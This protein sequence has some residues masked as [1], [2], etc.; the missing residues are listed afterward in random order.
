MK[1]MDVLKLENQ[2]C[3]P[4]YA[5]SRQITALYRPLLEALGLTYPQYLVLMVLWEHQEITVKQLGELLLL[6]SGT[7]TP[8]LKR[9]EEKGWVERTRSREDERVVNISLTTAGKKLKQKAAPIPEQLVCGIEMKEKDLK[10]LRD[11]L[12][13]MLAGIT[14]V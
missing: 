14:Q 1:S 3:F 5:A 9:M 10:T 7:L 12:N 6:D 4:L 11:L 13:K 2:I 8:L